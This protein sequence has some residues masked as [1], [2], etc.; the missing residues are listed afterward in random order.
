MDIYEYAERINYGADYL[1]QHTGYVYHIQE[2]GKAL[3][4]GFPTKGIR[5]SVNGTTIGY[6][7]KNQ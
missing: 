1:D 7:T 3:K 6:A 2:Y 4:Y 5:V